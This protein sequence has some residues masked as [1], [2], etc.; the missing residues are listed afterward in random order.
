MQNIFR[1]YSRA[2]R[3][4]RTKNGKNSSTSGNRTRGI[5]VTGRD[6]TNYTNADWKAPNEV[7]TRDLTLTKR[8]LCQL[9]YKGGVSV[10]GL[11]P[12]PDGPV[13]MTEKILCTKSDDPNA[14]GC[15]RSIANFALIQC[16]PSWTINYAVRQ[17]QRDPGP[18]SHHS[19]C[20]EH[21]P[22]KPSRLLDHG[23][24]PAR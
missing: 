5:C 14:C 8:M 11:F 6:V 10:L 22:A 4:F 23:V 17:P 21:A 15:T 3:P 18:P 7:R 2:R 19:E 12:H 20:N 24:D 1:S 9:S 13:S 16:C